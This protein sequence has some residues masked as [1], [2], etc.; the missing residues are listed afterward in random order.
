MV[1]NK[2]L[3]I[4]LGLGSIIAAWSEMA[5]LCLLLCLFLLTVFVNLF[6]N[7]L[8]HPFPVFFARFAIIIVIHKD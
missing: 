3:R 6:A 1:L 8:F 4:P 2:T 5:R 7:P